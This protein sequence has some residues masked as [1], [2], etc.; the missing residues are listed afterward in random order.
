M[1][2][3]VTAMAMLPGIVEIQKQCVAMNLFN[4]QTSHGGFQW[5]SATKRT[6]MIETAKMKIS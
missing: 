5:I 4:M 6:R 3:H 1:A 2:G